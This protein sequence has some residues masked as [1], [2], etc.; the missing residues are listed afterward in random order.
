MSLDPR[1]IKILK[2]KYPKRKP[3]HTLSA[4]EIKKALKGTK[5]PKYAKKGG[6]I[7]KKV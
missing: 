6:L 1:I 5:I 2:K 7:G 4:S 3:F